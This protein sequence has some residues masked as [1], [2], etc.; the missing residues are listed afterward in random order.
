MLIWNIFLHKIPCWGK[1]F[2]LKEALS[3]LYDRLS[4]YMTYASFP[5]SF[6][7]FYAFNTLRPRQN[8]CHFADDTFNH[9]F[10]TEN[11]GISIK[12]PLKFVPKGLI[13]N[14]QALVQIMAWRRPGDKPLSEPVMVSLLTHICVTRPQWVKCCWWLK[15]LWFVSDYLYSFGKAASSKV[16]ETAK[17]VKDA[18]E[19]KVGNLWRWAG[20]CLTEDSQNLFFSNIK[21][22]NHFTIKFCTS[23]DI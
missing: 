19:E 14:I 12:F 15:L 10:V 17:Q 2:L 20:N 3:L 4:K 6:S 8:G 13:N 23:T 18:V 16:A 9:I 1:N 22:K 7:I 5:G 11:V 21:C